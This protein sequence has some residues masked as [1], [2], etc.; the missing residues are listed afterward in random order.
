MEIKEIFSTPILEYEI[1][2]S[3]ADKVEETILPK[4]K[5]LEFTGQNYTDFFSSPL[6]EYPEISDLINTIYSQACNF[7]KK[8]GFKESKN[9]NYWIQDYKP[10]NYHEE[11][12]HGIVNLSGTYWV[13]ANQDAGNFV[14]RNPNPFISVSQNIIN[15]P[16]DYNNE[17]YEISPKKGKFILFPSFIFHSVK[18]GGS[19][20]IRT[21]LA[22]NF[23]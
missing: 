14:F 2:S 23:K 18:P 8:I 12:N 16:T 9:I 1:N 5:D 10:T 20:C 7:W 11:H 15:E 21:S 4:L 17:F 19:N 6:V 3:L 13:R 22:F